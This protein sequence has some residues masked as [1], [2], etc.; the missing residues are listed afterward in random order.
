MKRSIRSWLRRHLGSSPYVK[1]C[2]LIGSVLSRLR[3]N[4][5][6]VLVI[7]ES[8]NV[9]RWLARAK[10]AFQ[11]AFNLRLD[12]QLFHKTQVRDVRNFLWQAGCAVEV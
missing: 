2:W 9:R 6:D 5:V 4:D 8:W 1:E 3:F 12:V 7:C 10:A 11:R